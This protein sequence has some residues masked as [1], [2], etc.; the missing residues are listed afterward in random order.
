V[1]YSVVSVGVLIACFICYK[2]YKHVKADK[3]S[4]IVP[5]TRSNDDNNVV[6]ARPSKPSFMEP[7]RIVPLTLEETGKD[8]VRGAEVVSGTSADYPLQQ[9]PQLTQPVQVQL[10]GSSEESSYVDGDKNNEFVTYVDFDD[11]SSGKNSDMGSDF[12]ELSD[13]DDGLTGDIESTTVA[14][15]PAHNHS[16]AIEINNTVLPSVDAQE[17]TEVTASRALDV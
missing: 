9:Q 3:T 1:I 4:K 16:V 6:I 12:D 7:H 11:L 8:E 17:G 14:S 13:T 15:P 2:W 5:L 10:H